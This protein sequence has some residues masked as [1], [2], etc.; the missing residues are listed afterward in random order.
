MG[1]SLLSLSLALGDSDL[2]RG[3]LTGAVGIQGVETRALTFSSPERHWRMFRRREFDV[4]E[5]SFGALLSIQAR[6]P[7]EFVAVPAFPHR[8][9]RHSFVFVPEGSPIAAPSELNGKRIGLRTW[10]NSAGVWTRGILQDHYGLDLGSVEWVIQD[11]DTAGMENLPAAYRI[12]QVAPGTSIVDLAC[13]GE[14]DALIYPETPAVLGTPGGLRR[15]FTDARAAEVEY[16]T[17]TGIF[18]VMH[19]VAV[20][21]DIVDQNAWLPYEVLRAFRASKDLALD[22]IKD[23][24]KICL[25]WAQDAYEQQ[26][27]LMGE[28]PF[29]Y[30]AEGSRTAVETLIRYSVEQG[31]LPEPL[32]LEEIFHPTTMQEPPRYVR[33]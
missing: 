2:N 20:R 3:L 7:G 22:A 33:R 19:T 18:P 24:R 11:A 30:D 21:R 27:A 31:I 16:F 29:G 5:V 1:K 4:S 28:D 23:P 6:Q 32:T 15:L 12:H 17:N 10:T 13:R 8:R 26:V 25:A 9:F 14:I